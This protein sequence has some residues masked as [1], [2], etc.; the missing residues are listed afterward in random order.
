M[1][2]MS[3]MEEHPEANTDLIGKP[4]SKIIRF[5]A[6]LILSV[7]LILLALSYFIQV[8]EVIAADTLIRPVKFPMVITSPMS[9][10]INAGVKEGQWV[11]TGAAL[12]TVDG[13]AVGSPCSGKVALLRTGDPVEKNDTVMALLDS[14][15]VT[16]CA[17]LQVWSENV[18]KI[19]PGQEVM[20]TLSAFPAR[21]GM[22]QGHVQNIAV[23]PVANTYEVTV[24]LP[25]GLV[26][27][28]QYKIGHFVYLT[29]K[30]L[31]VIRKRSLLGRI[32]Q[33]SF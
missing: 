28:N 24:D 7:L 12:F 11:E 27:N 6:V 1:S 13:V 19:R 16:W 33:R 18:G 2:K 31:I 10:R 17:M 29:G 23:M 8:P 9:G 22:L 25:Q 20:I 4:P 5:G 15:A 26:T 3:W 21:Y 30:A 32:F 14:G